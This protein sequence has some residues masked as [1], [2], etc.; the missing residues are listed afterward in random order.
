MSEVKRLAK[1][2]SHYAAG[3]IVMMLLGF[4]SFPLFTRIFSV[5]AYGMM[6]LVSQLVLV[7]TAFAKG[8][9]QN[10]V[11]RYHR[12]HASSDD[13]AALRRFYSST[14]AGAAVF[15]AGTLAVVTLVTLAIP[16]HLVGNQ[17]KAV[18]V[19][20][21]G[22]IF[23]RAIKSMVAN[24]LQVE[25][26]TMVFNAVEIGIKAFTIL[27][28]ILFL[29]KWERT[30]RAFFLATL[31]VETIA[32]A[33]LLPYVMRRG[34]LK[35]KDIRGSVFKESLAF[36][37]PLMWSELSVIFL[38]SGDRLLIQY[39][40]GYAAVGY[41]AAAYGIAGYVY[42][43]LVTPINMSLM[44]ICMD[45]WVDKGAEETKRF[46]SSSLRHFVMLT[47]Y[48]ILISTLTA[49]ELILILASRKFESAV[50]LL[51]LLVGSLVLATIHSFFK[52]G[53][54]IK[55]R[56]HIVAAMTFASMVVNVAMNVYL[57][58]RIGI[59]GAAWATFAA[60]VFW[61][62]A[63]AI[64]SLRTFSY[65]MQWVAF[66]RAAVIAVLVG[67]LCY[68]IRSSHVMVEL[69]LRSTAATIGYL[70]L[71]FALDSTTRNIV[72]RL[73]RGTPLKAAT[74]A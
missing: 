72:L 12:E 62:V 60:Y 26:R 28:I 27:A 68:E 53:L 47:T 73:L 63:T 23:M 13:P 22:L 1:Y 24:L 41:Y 11:Q 45:I 37:F 35:W 58:P 42:D 29:F 54:M 16:A 32:L 48:I 31:L 2:S 33:P 64:V 14:F 50:S 38:D 20:S 8:G 25:G 7:F 39:F 55:K 65:E 70:G 10:S 3:R 59:M 5:E 44:P 34:L 36:G 18:L 66:A 17:L 30:V 4:V 56:P 57:L 43:L 46:L 52:A 6:A 69:L 71:L 67:L 19:I 49:R 40:L 15:A 21:W 51:P 9:L 74:T 61:V